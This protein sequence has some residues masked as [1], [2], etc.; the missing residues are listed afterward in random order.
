MPH[1]R[2]RDRLALA[3][4]SLPN[5]IRFPAISSRL[6]SA[7]LPL[8]PRRVADM[9]AGRLP[10]DPTFIDHML[11]AGLV[12][13]H[14]RRGTLDEI[15]AL[16]DWFWSKAPA[17]AFHE[18][19]ER[20][21]EDWF[22]GHHAAIVAPIRA[23]LA[24]EAIP[25]EAFCEIGCGCGR[26]LQHMAEALP[27]LPRFVG[28]D[29]SA[30]QVARNRA[31]YTSE[32][33]EFDSGD[34]L[35]WI[36]QHARPRWVYFTCGGVLEFFPRARVLELFSL[37]ASRLAPS[38][39]AMVEPLSDDHDLDRDPG[40]IVYGAENTFSH[41]YVELLRL[42]GFDL[43]HRAEQRVDDQRWLLLV[44]RSHAARAS[45]SH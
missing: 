18:F 23:A 45:H 11:I 7:L 9:K 26:A 43:L 2:P 14:Q 24:A 4:M 21:F 44:A 32:R 13:T 6:G 17:V 38:L 25:F 8:L 1:D 29:L 31:R 16:H 37:L 20:R 12:R 30:A 27:Q 41:N 3:P 35:Q 5:V 19:A 28:L 34:G 40:S 15:T 33:M 42:A 36:A 39:V 10:D 22:L